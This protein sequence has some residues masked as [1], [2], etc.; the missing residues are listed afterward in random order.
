MKIGDT[1]FIIGRY[2][3]CGDDV[4]VEAKIDHIQH[5]QFVAYTVGDEPGEWHFSR[6][7]VGKSVFTAREA[8][9]DA[10]HSKAGDRP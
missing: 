10:N 2:T 8:A 9:L 3:P 4:L 6:R 7:H 1:V 5:R